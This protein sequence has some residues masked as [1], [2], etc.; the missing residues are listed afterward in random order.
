MIVPE[1]KLKQDDRFVSVFIRVPYIK[2]TACE[3]YIEAN[4]FKFYL[5]PYLLSLSF[6]QRLSEAEEPA[7]ATYYHEKYILEVH[8]E[9]HTPGEHFNNLDLISSVVNRK[10]EKKSNRVSIEVIGGT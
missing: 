4:T 9:K 6:E 3:F 2:V 8:L 5:K 10:K 7:K 1:F